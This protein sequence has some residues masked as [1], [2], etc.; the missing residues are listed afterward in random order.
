M[1]TGNY[2]IESKIHRFETNGEIDIIDLTPKIREFL[3]D[4]SLVEGEITVF[5]NGSTGAIGTTEFEPRLTKD[6][7]N[8][9]SKLIPKGA[10]YHHDHIDNNAHSH[11]RATLI[12]SDKTIPVID[13]QLLIGTWQQIVFFEFDTR[14][15]NR[16]VIFQ[17]KGIL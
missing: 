16:S 2:F 13:N 15:R 8:I 6:N 17:A 7:K 5:V 9:F 12:G 14:P 10:G 1:T 11:L 4:T 3:H